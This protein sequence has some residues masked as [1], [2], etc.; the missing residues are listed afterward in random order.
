MTIIAGSNGQRS[1]W[2]FFCR[3]TKRLLRVLDKVKVLGFNTGFSEA[4]LFLGPSLVLHDDQ[5]V[6]S[7]GFVRDKRIEGNLY[8]LHNLALAYKVLPFIPP[9]KL[10][11][12]IVIHSNSLLLITAF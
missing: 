3:R 7:L 1:W 11:C 6:Y 10:D 12:H 5:H 4:R 2:K 9:G 8:I